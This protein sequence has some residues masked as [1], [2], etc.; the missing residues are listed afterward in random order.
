[1]SVPGEQLMNGES[2]CICRERKFTE[3]HSE[4]ELKKGLLSHYCCDRGA[5][6]TNRGINLTILGQKYK[7]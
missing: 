7:E 1:M 4:K 6:T 3:I 5:Y 2:W